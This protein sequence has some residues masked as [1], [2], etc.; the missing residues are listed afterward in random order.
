VSIAEL[1]QAGHAA[2]AGVAKKTAKNCKDQ[3][4]Q[5]CTS[6]IPAIANVFRDVSHKLLYINIFQE[7]TKSI[8]ASVMI[9]PGEPPV[10]Q[11]P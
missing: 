9:A 5:D 6:D 2:V 10:C 8:C 4:Q 1:L 11:P 7:E 3:T